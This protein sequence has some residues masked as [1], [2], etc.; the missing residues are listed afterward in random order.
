MWAI[1]RFQ[2]LADFFDAGNTLGFTRFELNHAIDSAMLAGLSLDGTIASIHEPCPADLS[3]AVLKERNWLISAPDE[4][5]RRLGV[6]AVLRSIDLA[7]QLGAHVVI[8]HPG[9]V[10]IDPS[11]ESALLQMYEEGKVGQPEYGRARERLVTARAVQANVHMP[12]VRR[13]LL[14]LAE[15][16]APKGVRLALENR[17][18]YFE[19]PLPDELEDLLGLG[20]GELVGYWHDVGHAQVLENLGLAAHEEWLRRFANRILGVHLHD[21]AGLT[22]HLAAGLGQMDWEMV[23]RYLPAE[24]LRTC[25]FQYTNSPEQVAAGVRWLAEKGCVGDYLGGDHIGSPLQGH[26]G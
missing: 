9:R 24:A 1:G 5:N 17:F 21:V 2:R 4:E 15:Y 3:M 16:A 18:H 13:S 23:A 26:G 25:E 19:I 12:P 22:D 6:A 11:L 7:H 10:D 8:V 14:E 20:C